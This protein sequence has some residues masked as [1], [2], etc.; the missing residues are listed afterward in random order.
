MIANKFDINKDGL[1]L[2]GTNFDKFESIAK[3]GLVSGAHFQ[4]YETQL[5][6]R[7]YYNRSQFGCPCCQDIPKEEY[8]HRRK[9]LFFT[10][11]GNNYSHYKKQSFRK[12]EEL[13]FGFPGFDFGI[14]ID[15]KNYFSELPSKKTI[16]STQFQMKVHFE[17]DIEAEKQHNIFKYYQNLQYEIDWNI[18]GRSDDRSEFMMM[19]CTPWNKFSALLVNGSIIPG[20]EYYEYIATD[21][22]K[23]NSENIK[24]QKLNSLV[25][26]IRLAKSPEE[27][28]PIY[29]TE[30]NL[31]YEPKLDKIN[32]VKTKIENK[33]NIPNRISNMVLLQTI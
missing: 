16:K 2:H 6:R 4:N 1:L 12:G 14:I 13:P 26:K 8:E 31:L 27:R 28:I 17:N 29:D 30:N 22:E 21:G 18:T 10:V 20:S 7:C 25:S 32:Y 3:Y 19:S 24:F 23:M 9:I 33:N 11:I 5:E 15:P